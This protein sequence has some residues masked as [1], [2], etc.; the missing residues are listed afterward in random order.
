MGFLPESL[1]FYQQSLKIKEQATYT[2]ILL[3][4][5]ANSY[6]ALKDEKNYA[7]YRHLL[8]H[9]PQNGQGK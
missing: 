7:R 1:K 3:E 4:N 5:L 2:A 9:Y 6:K 8:D